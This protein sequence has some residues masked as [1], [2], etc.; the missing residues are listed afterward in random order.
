MNYNLSLTRNRTIEAI[1]QFYGESHVLVS[2]SVLLDWMYKNN[3]GKFNVATLELNS[4]M[5]A[6][7]AYTHS[8]RFERS[9]SRKVLWG[10]LWA[11]DSNFPGA[12]VSVLKKVIKSFPRYSFCTLGVSRQAEMIYQSLGYKVSTLSHYFMERLGAK[13]TI[14]NIYPPTRRLIKKLSIADLRYFLDYPHGLFGGRT[15]EYVLNRYL[16]HPRFEYQIYGVISDNILAIFVGR[17]V[18]TPDQTFFRI[19]EFMHT[20]STPYLGAEISVWLKETGLDFIDFYCIGRHRLMEIG[21]IPV[22]EQ[23][24]SIFPHFVDPVEYRNIT[25]KLIHADE[26][27]WVTRGDGDQDRPNSFR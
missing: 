3:S 23:C 1:S 4:R 11:A 6:M 27:N 25:L 10:S 21:W 15:V 7:L 20:D 5:I 14:T 22:N 18:T 13:E 17:V 16:K 12:G 24:A 26:I 2:D 9:P 19:V 8:T